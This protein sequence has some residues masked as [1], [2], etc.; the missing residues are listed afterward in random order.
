M[1]SFDVT[2]IGNAIIDVIAPC[3]DQFLTDFNIE[4]GAMT[5]IDQPRAQELYQAMTGTTTVSGGS[6]ANTM[7]G[8]ASFGGRGNYIG[9]IAADPLGDV[10]EQEC[11]DINLAYSTARFEGNLET[12]RCYIFVTPDGERSMNTF[13]GASSELSERHINEDAVASSS[14]TYMEGYLFDKDPAK[15]GFRKAAEIAHKNGHKVALTLSDSFCVHRHRNDFLHLVEDNIDILFANEDELKSLYQTDNLDAAINAVRGHCV[16]AAVTRSEQGS[17]IVTADEIMTIQ[18]Q[19]VSKV[20]D[21]TGAGDQYAA[22]FLYGLTTGADL[23]TCGRYGSLAA[24]EVITHIGPRPQ[25][26]YKTL[27]EAA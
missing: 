12:A 14:I 5:L 19:A 15:A 17:V 4:R 3:D 25:V 8:F 1:T 6:A 26:S 18:P 9:L 24:S 13:L 16:I 23:A 11:R 2:G 21:T 27:R 20:V 10:F 7:A 22:G